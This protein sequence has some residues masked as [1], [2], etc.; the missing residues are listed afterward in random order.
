M[1]LMK[2]LLYLRH[3]QVIYILLK[4]TREDEH[5]WEPYGSAALS[6]ITGSLDLKGNIVYWAHETFADT[7]YD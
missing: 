1:R 5:C 3:Y 4:W 7:F 6:V 2:L